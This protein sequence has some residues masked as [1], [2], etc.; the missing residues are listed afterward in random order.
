M[1]QQILRNKYLGS[2][3]LSQ[4]QWEPGDSHFWAS[5]MRVKP[6]F[7]KM[8]L[9]FG[10]GKING[11]LDG[12]AITPIFFVLAA[13]FYGRF[14]LQIQSLICLAP[15]EKLLRDSIPVFGPTSAAYL[16]HGGRSPSS[17]TTSCGR[18]LKSS[19]TRRTK[20]GSR[21]A[22]SYSQIRMG[23]NFKEADT[24]SVP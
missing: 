3:P 18:P 9:K 4:V 5:L 14:E 17:T 1:W 20:G 2:Q 11:W 7:L 21:Y 6:D 22:M 15:F 19:P 12:D 13:S 23:Q 16:P 10:F 8:V 24:S